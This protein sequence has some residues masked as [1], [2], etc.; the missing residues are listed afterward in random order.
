MSSIE[1]LAIVPL[2]VGAVGCSQRGEPM[3]MAHQGFAG[4]WR[5]NRQKSDMPS[6]TQSQVLEIKT[7]GVLVA[8]RETLANDR[9]ETLT[10]S[11]DGR[12]DGLDYPVTGTPFADT[13]SYRLR[14]PNMIEGVAKKGGVVVVQETAVLADDGMSVSVTYVSFDGQGKSY[15]NHGV[16]ERVV[17]Q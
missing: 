9:G 2:L 14:A 7:D 5:L 3:A 1:R 15:V 10:I 12:F 13:V 6:V 16:F 17:R 4:I 11:V 8:M